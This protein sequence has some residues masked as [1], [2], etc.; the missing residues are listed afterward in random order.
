MQLIQ[1][2]LEDYDAIDSSLVHF[3]KVVKFYAISAER[4][5]MASP[6]R[7]RVLVNV[8]KIKVKANNLLYEIG[9]DFLQRLL[10]E[11][12]KALEE[13]SDVLIAYDVFSPNNDQRKS[14]SYCEEQL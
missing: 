13:A 5:E 8:N 4:M 12:N 9:Y 14:M 7:N 11:V 1:E 3:H 10:E 6:F 2:G